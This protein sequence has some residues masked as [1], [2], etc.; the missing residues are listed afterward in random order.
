MELTRE[1]EERSR[2]VTQLEAEVAA[3]NS[4]LGVRTD[5]ASSIARSKEELQQALEALRQ[6]SAAR[7]ARVAELETQSAAA[8]Q[9]IPKHCAPRPGARELQDN[10]RP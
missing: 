10:H 9:L 6:E 5:Q 1:L 3:L 4:K 7:A 8:D 2:R